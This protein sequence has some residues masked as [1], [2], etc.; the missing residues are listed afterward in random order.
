[1]VPVNHGR[2][3]TLAHVREDESTHHERKFLTK[4]IRERGKTLLMHRMGRP[5]EVMPRY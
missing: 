2:K 4:A 3:V 1:M 5:Q